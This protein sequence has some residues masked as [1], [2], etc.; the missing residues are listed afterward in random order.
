[1]FKQTEPLLLIVDE[2]CACFV[3]FETHANILALENTCFHTKWNYRCFADKF[4][5][6]HTIHEQ[7][8]RQ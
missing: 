2:L 6:V 4:A 5:T 7:I 3:D 8:T 1:L